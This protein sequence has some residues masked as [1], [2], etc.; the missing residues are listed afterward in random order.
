[1]P[2]AL[3]EQEIHAK[4]VNQIETAVGRRSDVIICPENSGQITDSDK[5]KLVILA[6]NKTLSSRSSEADEA[7]PVAEEFLRYCGDE[8]TRRRYKN[9]VLFLTS[10]RDEIRTLKNTIRPYLAWDSIINGDRKIPNLTGD[11]RR[12]AMASLT[13]ASRDIDNALVK[14]YRWALAPK[15]PDPIQDDYQWIQLDT[16]VGQDGEIVGSAFAIFVEEEVLIEK[17]SS[18]KLDRTL[19]EYVWNNPN[20]G[21]HIKIDD[22]WGLLAKHVYLPRLRNIGVLLECIKQGVPERAFGYAKSYA[23]SEFRENEDEEKEAYTGSRFGEDLGFGMIEATGLL[24]NPDRAQQKAQEAPTVTPDPVETPSISPDPGPV[25][26]TLPQGPTHFIATKT[27]QAE[28]SF[29][30]INLLR[31]EIIRTMRNDGADIRITITIEARK[32]EGFSENAARSIR[33]NS[34]VLGVDLKQTK[35]D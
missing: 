7:T 27:M 6:P 14:A 15:Q 28:I 19:R 5:I 20:Y 26:P 8:T 10:K 33:Q 23:E 31:D 11:R 3:T 4:I 9:T 16:N 18:S 22:L 2:D 12:Q 32:S 21:N 35:G 24:V 1:M 30:D 34:D 25:T 17:V 13:K 29:D